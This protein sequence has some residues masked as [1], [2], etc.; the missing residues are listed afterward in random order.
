MLNTMWHGPEESTDKNHLPVTAEWIAELSVERYRP[1]LRLLDATDLEFLREQP[2][3][4]S[5]MAA[6]LRKQRIHVFKGYLKNL[7]RDFRQSCRALRLLMVQASYDRPDLARLVIRKQATFE[8]CLLRARWRL[9]LYGWGMGC[10]DINCLMRVFDSVRL[11]LQELVPA[12][13]SN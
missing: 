7:K 13:G 8:L 1:M 11:E 2:G 6:R 3:F 5:R 4:D 9:L 12:A 10:V